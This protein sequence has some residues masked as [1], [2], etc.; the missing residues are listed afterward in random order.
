MWEGAFVAGMAI[1]AGFDLASRRVPNR[2]TI[3]LFASGLL[4]RMWLGGAGEVGWGLAG[5]GVGL[6]LLIVP[7]AAGWMGGGDVKLAGAIG[8]WLGPAGVAWAVLSGLAA[9]GL[10]ALVTLAVGGAALRGEV[11]TNLKNAWL[12]QRVP[13]VGRRPAG[14]RVPLAVALAAAAV[15]VLVHAGGLHAS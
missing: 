5:A 10:L 15:G 1:A 7:F 13:V 2:L 11:A 6:A 4:A 3:G 9:G 8:A 12:A 14:K